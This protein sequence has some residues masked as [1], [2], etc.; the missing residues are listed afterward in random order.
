MANKRALINGIIG[1]DGSYLVEF[2]LN[3]NYEVFGL[4]RRTSTVNFE[5]IKYINIVDPIK[6]IL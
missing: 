5:R 6:K 1:Q 4:T 2:L 3:K